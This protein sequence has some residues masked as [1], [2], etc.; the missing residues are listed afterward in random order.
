MRRLA[1]RLIVVALLVLGVVA[2]V[3]AVTSRH[4]HDRA[5][6]TPRAT[7]RAVRL[8]AAAPTPYVRLRGSPETMFLPACDVRRLRLSLSSAPELV[9]RYSGG[10]CHVAPL[11]LHALVL[12]RAGT[13]LY[14]GRALAGEPFSR[15]LAG[16]TRLEAPLLP[17]LLRCGSREPLVVLV[18]GSGL[19]TRGAVHCRGAF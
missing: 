14:R 17:R 7:V 15:N 9:L 5:A 19:G 12:D 6:P 10:R 18:T 1:D 2:A 16:P 3:D 13:I 11:R 4:R 8:P